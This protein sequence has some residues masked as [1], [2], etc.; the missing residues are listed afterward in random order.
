MMRIE[1]R[2]WTAAGGWEGSGEPLGADAGLVLLFGGR[3]AVAGPGCWDQLRARYPRAHVVGCSTA[4][5]ICGTRVLDD[6][7][8]ATAIAFRATEVEVGRVS[9]RDVPDSLAAGGRL[10]ELLDRP[11]LVHVLVL[12]EGLNVNGSELV[13]GLS[14]RLPSTVGVSGGLSGDGDRFQRT[15]VGVDGCVAEDTVAGIGFYGG[16]LRVGCGSLGGWDPFG[17]ERLITR[18]K[19]NVLYE[20]DG[21]SALELYRL[22]LGEHADELPASGLRFPL[23]LRLPDGEAG[24][25]RTIL[26]V[27]EREQSLTFAGDV[28]EG[29]FARLMKANFE[30]LIDGATGAARTSYRAIGEGTPELAVLISCVGRKLILKQ[31]VEEEVESVRE[32]L[33]ESPVLA[34]FYSYGEIS[35]FTPSTR[36][37]L[38]NQTMTITTF[39]EVE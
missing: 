25:V 37:E 14:R 6:S 2:K 18:S 24:V 7:V 19:G 22:Y 3:E 33:G 36:C 27:D 30:R 21:R 1:Q 12:S 32:V 4:G 16:A 9:L 10:G 8:V 31:R 34:G 26:G 38:H 29:A 23:S 15:L 39:A 13:R 35:P 11:G 28:P 17:P 20:L 5:E